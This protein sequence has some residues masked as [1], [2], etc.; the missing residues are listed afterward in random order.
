[1]LCSAAL[2][3]AISAAPL[4]AQEAERS[5]GEITD[6]TPVQV[7][8]LGNS[9]FYYNDS[10][11]NHARRLAAAHFGVSASD[12][13][14]RSITISGGSLDGHP[15]DIWLKPDGIGYDEPF[16]VVILQGHSA[17][18]LSEERVARFTDAAVAAD[19][20]ID[21]Y[22]AR[23]ALY[24]TH[25]YAEE[26]RR[27]DEGNTAAIE[28]LYRDVAQQTG[29]MV[30]PVGLAFEE[31]RTRRPDLALHTRDDSHPNLLGSYLA[32]ATVFSSLYGV[33]PVGL[34]YDAN[35]EI[36]AETAEFLQQV[37]WDT[38]QAL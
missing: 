13:D 16:D 22:G 9:Y 7:L 25:A 18:A 35:G 21:E 11:H 14:Y 30:I 24:M 36:D 32:A 20:L 15:V 37:A 8:F 23:T 27:H 12:M 19:E 5:P 4:L 38:V 10:L 1:M 2:A 29:A 28:A 3:L 33:S 31:A 26:H 6:D 34:G 17:A